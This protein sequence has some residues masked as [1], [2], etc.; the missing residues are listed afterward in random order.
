MSSKYKWTARLKSLGDRVVAA[1]ER[2][3]Q[4]VLNQHGPLV[5]I[6]VRVADRRRLDRSRPQ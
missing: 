3:L 4:G 1:A 5:P 2:A 6:P